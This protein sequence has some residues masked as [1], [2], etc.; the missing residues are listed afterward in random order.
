[1]TEPRIIPNLLGPS[2]F[3]YAQSRFTDLGIHWYY[4]PVTS[5]EKDQMQYAGSF[6]HLIYKNGEPI[7]PLWDLS[8]QILLAACDHHGERLAEIARVRLGFCTRTPYAVEHTPHQ[9]FQGPHRTGIYY[10]ITADGPTT[11]YAEKTEQLDGAYTLLASQQPRANLWMDF[12][13]EHFHSSTTP[14]DHEN[15]LVLTLNYRIQE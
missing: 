14:V 13:G 15:R 7:S 11:I 6:S 8:L 12:D 3:E 9:D 5:C 10:P 2:T 1:M 4:M